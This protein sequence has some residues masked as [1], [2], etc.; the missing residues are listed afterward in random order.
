MIKG[1]LDTGEEPF[2]PTIMRFKGKKSWQEIPDDSQE[3]FYNL[4]AA[5]YLENWSIKGVEYK[6]SKSMSIG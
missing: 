2:V 3:A 5:N 1:V 6:I 4:I